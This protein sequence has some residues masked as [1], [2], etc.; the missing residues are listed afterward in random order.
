MVLKQQ[1]LRGF[2]YAIVAAILFGASTPIAK[3][4]LAEVD[5]WLLA[6]ILYLGSGIGLGLVHLFRNLFSVGKGEIPLKGKDWLWLAGATLFGGLLAPVAL[7]FGL[8]RTAPASTSLLLNLESLFTA[9]LA[10][11]VFHEYFNGRMLIGL[12]IIL[13]ASILLSWSG[14]PTFTQLLGPLLVGG[15]CVG[16]AIDN[17]LTR[18]ISAG[19]AL[20]IVMI[21]CLVAGIVNTA[22]AL[23]FGGDALPPFNAVMAVA[24]IGFL[25]YG[26]SL[27]C[28][29][30]ALRHIGAAR[31]G[32]YF[33][34][35]PFAGA[36]IS[37]A[38]GAEPWSVRFL[39]SGSLMAIGAWMFLPSSNDEIVGVG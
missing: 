25:G 34:F 37:L 12:C 4:L 29:V 9:L 13:A 1:K 16:W 28:F 18:Q 3:R 14:H 23:R 39:V 20:Q 15:A 21:K 17:N 19:D 30:L 26:L 11:F 38:T 5:A 36:A 22:L 7:M 35:A 27:I 6:G 33:S 24:G 10:W 2:L 8:A 32:A 31:T